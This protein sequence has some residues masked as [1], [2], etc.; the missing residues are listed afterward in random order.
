MENTQIE[1]AARAPQPT[2]VLEHG[3]FDDGSSWN[4]VIADLRRPG[5][6]VGAAANPLR[7][8][9]GQ[10]AITAAAQRPVP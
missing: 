8:V 5:Y 10:A 7:T 4:G 9:L 1:N 2:F 6:P 3:A